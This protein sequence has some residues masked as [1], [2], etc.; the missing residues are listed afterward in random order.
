VKAKGSGATG[1]RD[2][3][4][5]TP[6]WLRR[7]DVQVPV[8][9]LE[10]SVST[11]VAV[12]GAGVSGALITDALLASGFAVV[13]LDR[14]GPVRGS[15]P[16]STALLQFELDQPL[17][18]LT[19][20]IGRERAARAYW[21]SASAVDALRGRI[22][23]LG[24]RCGFRERRTVYLPGNVLRGAE[25]TRE[26]EA[27]AKI[28][29][30]SRRIGSQEL[31]EL[32][33]IER[34]GAILSSG[35]GEL[36]PAAFVGG[37]WKSAIARGAV[38]HAPTEVVDVDSSRA[39]VVLT[40][41]EGPEVRAKHVVFATGYELPK[42]VKPRGYGVISTW[43]MATKPQP[44]KL[45]PSRCLI[46][47]AADPYLYVRTT[48]DGRVI[49]GGEDE[50]F[51]DEDQRNAL[52]AKKIAAIER[53]LGR[54]IPGID[55]EAEFRWS[56]CFGQSSTGLPA[57]GLIP[58]SPRCFAVLGYGGNGITFSTIAAQV[59]QRAL[60]GIEDPDSDL[61]ALSRWARGG[62]A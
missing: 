27:R 7:G 32:T 31:R 61:F 38:V 25:L 56:G 52:T 37:L 23:D 20:K 62:G 19:R 35:A 59:I 1:K 8:R 43:A 22:A 57:I 21:R 33:R 36:D 4:D 15:T 5:G 13:V 24:L 14:R 12:I 30:R 18:H 2:L 42:L 49:A 50:K 53:K 34:P 60:L 29:L 55:T 47:E 6:V 40:T 28:G 54:L 46:W 17:I 39:R 51:E 3:R 16:A 58:G 45:W 11:D 44:K 48:L 9:P 10:R 26:A 41:K